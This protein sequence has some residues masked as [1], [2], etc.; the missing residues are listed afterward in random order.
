[1]NVLPLLPHQSVPGPR[2]H[3]VTRHQS[4][5]IT[6][7]MSV[8]TWH[9]HTSSH[10]WWFVT[11]IITCHADHHMTSQMT[12]ITGHHHRFLT[13]DVII[14]CHWCHRMSWP[15]PHTPSQCARICSGVAGIWDTDPSLQPSPVSLSLTCYIRTRRLGAGAGA[16]PLPS[17]SPSLWAGPTLTLVTTLHH[18]NTNPRQAEDLDIVDLVSI[19]MQID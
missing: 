1:M 17:P 4:R 8:M 18:L 2:H 3:S 16:S 6:H 10:L 5:V 13:S 7:H 9:H 11:S 12:D 19:Q 15:C 14:T